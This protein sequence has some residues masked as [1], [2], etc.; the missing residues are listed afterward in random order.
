MI[1]TS[2]IEVLVIEFF[3]EGLQHLISKQKLQDAC[4]SSLII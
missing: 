1:Q 3:S 4:I 2:V